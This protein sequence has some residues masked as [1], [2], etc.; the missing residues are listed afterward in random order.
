MSNYQ[1]MSRRQLLEALEA[2]DQTLS[3]YETRLRDVVRAYKGLAKEKEALEETVKAL[4]VAD[5]STKEEKDEEKIGIF[6]LDFHWIVHISILNI[7]F[8]Q[9]TLII[10]NYLIRMS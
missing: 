5:E 2:K 1:D 10:L 4:S 9:K 8:Q 3:R 7:F 6:F